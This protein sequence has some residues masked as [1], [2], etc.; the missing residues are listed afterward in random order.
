MDNDRVRGLRGKGMPGFLATL[1]ALGLLLLGLAGPSRAADSA[2]P[3]PDHSPSP[4]VGE[5][6]GGGNRPELAGLAIPFVEN[7]GQQDPAVAFYAQTLAGTVYVTR[8]GQLVY[9]LPQTEAGGWTLM[10]EAVGAT[11]QVSAG[12]AA[13]TQ[14]SYFHG[15]DPAQWRSGVS[16]V[17][18]VELGEPWP[19]VRLAVQAR[20]KQVEKLFTLAPG[21]SAEAIQMQL[22]GAQG[23]QIAD[24]GALHLTTG[25]G[26]V[27]FT[28]PQAWQELAGERR[29][30]A[31]AYQRLADDRYGFTLGEHDPQA[32][33]VIDP[34]LQSTYVGGNSD[35]QLYAMAIH[36][37][38]GEVYLTGYT[39]SGNFPGTTGG[40][41]PGFSGSYDVFLARLSADLKTLQQATYLGGSGDDRGFRIVIDPIAPY[42]VYVPCWTYSTNMP[43]TVGGAQP[44]NGG[45]QDGLVA[46][47][48]AD[49]KTLRQATYLGSAGGDTAYGLAIHP[50]GDIYVTGYT[51]GGFPGTTGG[52]Q[53]TF[54]GGLADPYVAR[55]SPDLKTLLQA[56]YLGGNGADS[57]DYLAIHPNRD[58]YV[59]GR[60]PST[61]FPG[62]TG[63]A[64][65]SYGGAQDTFVVRLNATLTTRLQA[66]Y[67][68][69]SGD[70]ASSLAI[71]PNGDINGDIYVGGSTTSTN[72]PGTAGGAQPSSG[73]GQDGFA[74]RLSADL[75]TLLQATYLGGSGSDSTGLAIHPTTSGEIY[76]G[77]STTSTNFPGTAGGAQP[78]SGGGQD[79]FAARLSADL[80]TLL[81]ATYLGGS[82]TDGAG[83]AIH[84]VS[85]EVYAGGHTNSINFPATA[86]GAQASYGGGANDLFVARLTAD[87]RGLT[88]TSIVRADPNPTAAASVTWTVTLSY[89]VSGL[90]ASNFTLVPTGVTGA[91]LT[92][93]TG[94]GTTWTVT[95]S[96]GTGDGTLGLNLTTTTG[97]T[98][99]ITVLP[100]TGEA[101]TINKTTPPATVAAIALADPSPTAAASVNW[102]VTFSGAVAGLSASNFALVTGGGVTG[103]AISGVSGSGATW[104]VTAGT[105][106]GDGTLGLNLANAAGLTPTVTNVPFTGAVYTV[107]KSVPTATV[108]A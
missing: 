49:L 61:D 22:R 79:G 69:G 85:G 53:A 80:K 34:L 95:A 50:N 64:Q 88:V 46:R 89:P 107:N 57:G 51:F 59:S 55:L 41:Q 91:S 16:T 66:T 24:D 43:G 48:S 71:R 92:S 2:L 36:P 39:T 83:L 104:T 3:P 15:N 18:S 54:G 1:L 35:E 86:G 52:A 38:S 17:H 108:A 96:T 47:L 105:G 72:F 99:A 81:Q 9:A 77:G 75:K 27:R 20:G 31:V 6:R 21:V 76:A 40:A 87:L 90:T 93:V 30:V 14:V 106:T 60:T 67:L 97:V 100:F 73:G 37:A 12:P 23:L 65:A 13:A 44:S 19:G 33:V 32:P 70:E 45:G 63:G 42:D 101:Y 58:I 82:G 78:S 7:Q 25:Q 26:E 68:G 84:P 29:A 11:P 56:T 103:A 28:A 74:A 94:S 98:P 5:G 8:A 62:T 4:L 10:E 102:T